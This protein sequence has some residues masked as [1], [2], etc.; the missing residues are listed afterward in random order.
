VPVPKVPARLAGCF[1]VG[2][3]LCGGGLCGCLLVK[4]R[5]F[6]QRCLLRSL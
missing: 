4:P 6:S 3:G 1:T 5:E 2:L